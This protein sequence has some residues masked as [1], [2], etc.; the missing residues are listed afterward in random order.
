MNTTLDE[1]NKL[2]AQV[3]NE[4]TEEDTEALQTILENGAILHF[5]S[6]SLKFVGIDYLMILHEGHPLLQALQEQQTQQEQNIPELTAHF[7]TTK[8]LQ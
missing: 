8:N 3:L 5:I 4:I 1:L 6:R 7:D 2:A